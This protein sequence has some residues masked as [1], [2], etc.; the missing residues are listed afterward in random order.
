MNR[1]KLICFA[2]FLLASTQLRA[3]LTGID[4]DKLLSLIDEGVPVIDVRRADEWADLGI[5]EGSHLMTF[6]DK[7]GRYDANA[8][9]EAFSSKVDTDQPF[10]LICHSGTRTSIIGKWLAKQLDEVYHVEDGIKG[11]I[12]E[13]RPVVSP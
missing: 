1:L 13:K 8:W 7:E 4:N 9:F 5:V 11:W 10:I 6:F 3:D 2:A 12:D